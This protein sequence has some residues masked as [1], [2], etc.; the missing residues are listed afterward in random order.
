[1]D[2]DVKQLTR[3][4]RESDDIYWRRFRAALRSRDVDPASV[5]LV[6]RFGAAADIAVMQHEDGRVIYAMWKR[7]D[8]DQNEFVGWWVEGVGR[9]PAWLAAELKRV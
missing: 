6:R 9:R 2:E 4:M 7:D 3:T 8:D 1:V 5:D